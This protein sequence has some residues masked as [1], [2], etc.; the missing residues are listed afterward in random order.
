M[1]AEDGARAWPDQLLGPLRIELIGAG[2][3]VAED[4]RQALPQE[5]VRRRDERERRQDDFAGEAQGAKHESEGGR[6]VARR[7][8]V[9]HARKRGDAPLELAHERPLV[10]ESP[11]VEHLLDA[12]QDLAAVGQVRCADVQRLGERGLA[13]EHGQ[14]AH[15]APA[16]RRSSAQ[17]KPV[18]PK[19][20]PL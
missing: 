13:A 15:R 11:A 5:G 19:P 18:S 7:D 14:R 4:R 3:D 20:S 16:H 8:A 9:L 1:H 2:G 6:R 17:P 12:A 10:S